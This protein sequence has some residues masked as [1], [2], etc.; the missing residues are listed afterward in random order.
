[1]IR[2]GIGYDLHRLV[3]G[4]ELVLGGVRIPHETGLLGHS[5]GDA[6]LHA[7]TDAILG[8]LAL[9]DIGSHFPDTEAQ[10]KDASSL[11]LLLTVRRLIQSSG[12][13]VVNI[14]SV[15]IAEAPRMRPY[16][17]SMRRR[18]AECLEVPMEAVSVK[19]KTNETVGPEGR[20][21]AISTQ[22]VVLLEQ[23]ERAMPAY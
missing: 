15:I 17:E 4:R 20:G 14:D 7:I 18:I 9:G 16:I 1:V 22:A 5:D 6:L 11:D 8:A 3:E 12:Y 10:Y 13:R 19:A 23:A 2:I 21:E